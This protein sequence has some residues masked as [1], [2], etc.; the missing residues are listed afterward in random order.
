MRSRTASWPQREVRSS[1]SI[2]ECWP[3]SSTERGSCP[4]LQA[5]RSGC[6]QR[7]EIVLL[8]REIKNMQQV[9]D[10]PTIP[11]IATVG[12][13]DA[14]PATPPVIELRGLSVRLGK[15]E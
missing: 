15:R 14:K 10:T 8:S 3:A 11:S 2:W 7:Q 4:W 6:A 1:V 12:A 9:N 13:F 5:A